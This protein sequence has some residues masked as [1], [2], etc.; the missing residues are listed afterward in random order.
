M[1]VVFISPKQRQK[2]FFMGITV[3]FALLVLFVSLAVFLSSPT[4]VEPALVFNKT[5]ININMRIIDSEKFKEL[6]PYSEIAV[7]FAYTATTKEDKD[8][9]G[10]VTAVSEEEAKKMLEAAGFIE[11]SL[12]E[13]D[14]GRNN[15]FTPYY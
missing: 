8:V 1:A 2:M 10:F 3:V 15:P 12:K 9:E 5:K 14:M 13:V 6:S 7:Q 4:E 11:I